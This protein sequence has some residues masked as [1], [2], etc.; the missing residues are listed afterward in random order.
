MD[1]VQSYFVVNTAY[2]HD[3]YPI[4]LCKHSEDWL[5]KVPIQDVHDQI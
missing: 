4:D 5:Q 3:P 1:Q 2:E